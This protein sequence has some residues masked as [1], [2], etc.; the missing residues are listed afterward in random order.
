MVSQCIVQS[1]TDFIFV[2]GKTR[3]VRLAVFDA[4]EAVVVT[5]ELAFVGRKDLEETFGVMDDLL[6]HFPTSIDIRAVL[7]EVSNVPSIS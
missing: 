6:I 5:M 4:A 2:V 3:S 1:V 7:V